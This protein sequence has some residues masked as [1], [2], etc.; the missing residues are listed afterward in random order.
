MLK[1]FFTLTTDDTPV[2]IPTEPIPE[3]SAED[4]FQDAKH[5]RGIEINGKQRKID[6]KVIEPYKKVLSHGGK[7]FA[8]K[9]SSL[10][11]TTH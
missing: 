4:E 10:I 1:F 2:S 9:L 11:R 8:G 3:Y 5:W 6:L 7:C